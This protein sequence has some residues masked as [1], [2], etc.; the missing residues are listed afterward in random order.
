[1]FK[2]LVLLVVIA[3]V[4]W[5]WR[6]SARPS[7]TVSRPQPPAERMVACAYC[8]VN[9]PLSESLAVEDR[10]YCCDAHRRN[11]EETSKP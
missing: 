9:Q 2:Y 11:G 7:A 4:W 1:M 3:V 5:R 6:E 10:F 8:G